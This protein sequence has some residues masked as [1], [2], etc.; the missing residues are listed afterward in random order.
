MNGTS[1]GSIS[2]KARIGR[3]FTF[4]SR[5]RSGRPSR[6]REVFQEVIKA[7]KELDCGIAFTTIKGWTPEDTDKYGAE[8]YAVLTSVVTED[9]MTVVRGV[10]DG[11]GWEVWS[12]LF[13][14]FDPRTPATTLMAVM[15]VMHRRRPNTRGI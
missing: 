1:A 7:G 12:R 10:M 15:S 3:S 2:S 8:L 14:R 11:N 4:S 13:N 9:A 6:V 5:R